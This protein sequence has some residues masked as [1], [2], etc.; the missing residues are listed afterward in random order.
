M[1]NEDA[2][3]RYVWLNDPEVTLH[4]T[5]GYP[6]SMAEVRAMV[7]K[8]LLL[9]APPT[10]V[11]AIDTLEGRHIGVINLDHFNTESRRC[12]LGIMIG[13]KDCWSQGYGTD[14]IL[15]LL[16]FAFDEINLHRV[17]L[18]VN[19]ENGR[20]R[21]CYRK[22]GFVDE[23]TLRQHRFKQGVYLDSIIMGVLAEDFRAANPRPAG[24]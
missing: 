12:E 1:R 13:E 10:V 18:D 11:L 5:R 21:A 14:A 6:V 22:C 17:W 8:D 15:T 2:E 9:T 4:Y 24:I 3:R 23:V 7:E 16:R 19:A 20:A